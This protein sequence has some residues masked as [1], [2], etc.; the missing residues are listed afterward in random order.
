TISI[1]DDFVDILPTFHNLEKLFLELEE[2][3]DKSVFPLL[4]AAPN[5]TRLVFNE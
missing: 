4:K 5:L 2:T 1:V 3:S